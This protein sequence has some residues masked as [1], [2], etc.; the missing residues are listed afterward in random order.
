MEQEYTLFEHLTEL[1]KR[2]IIIVV[3]FVLSLGL[4]FSVS[5]KLL[6]FIKKQPTA[7]DVDW[8]VFGFTDGILIY[9]PL[10]LQFL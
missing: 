5:S 8:N 10:L 6:K 3:T 2:L 1:R 7:V 9:L 4:G